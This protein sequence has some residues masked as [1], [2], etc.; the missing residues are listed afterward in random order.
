MYKTKSRYRNINMKSQINTDRHHYNVRLHIRQ[1]PSRAYGMLW[2]AF[3]QPSQMPNR[4]A[5]LCN[6]YLLLNIDSK[7]PKQSTHSF[8]PLRND[9]SLPYFS[10]CC[11]SQ[12]NSFPQQFC[13]P[14]CIAILFC[15]LEGLFA[16][17]IAIGSFFGFLGHHSSHPKPTR[18]LL[19]AACSFPMNISHNGTIIC[20]FEW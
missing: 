9:T 15:H 1:S 6:V 17:I 7:L 10:K 19:L 2:D 16:M 5:I 12:C 8:Q 20:N 14:H 13:I 3:Q 11:N 18:C 4:P